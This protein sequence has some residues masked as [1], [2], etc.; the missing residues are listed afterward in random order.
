[1]KWHGDYHASQVWLETSF[2]G[3]RIRLSSWGPH[4]EVGRGRHSELKSWTIEFLTGDNLIAYGS[5][6]A[7]VEK[8]ITDDE[9]KEMALD[10]VDRWLTSTQRSLRAARGLL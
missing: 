9:A 2:G 3:F 8:D 4:A 7:E 10:I 6:W 5:T 1:M